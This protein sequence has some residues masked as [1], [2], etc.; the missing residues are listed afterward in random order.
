MS[1]IEKD[2]LNEFFEKNKE[3]I[4]RAFD[5]KIRSLDD[6][7]LKASMEK[8]R[9]GIINHDARFR[10][11]YNGHDNPS[12]K[13]L[14][15]EVVAEFTKYR[16]REG[17]RFDE[18]N[19]EITKKVKRSKPSVSEEKGRVHYAIRNGK[20]QDK[21]FKDDNGNDFYVTNQWSFSGSNPT[22]KR[23][24]DYVDKN[25]GGKFEIIEL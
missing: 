2:L 23:F 20:Y 8:V 1:S 24:K 7:E 25:Y 10:V 4:L 18:I 5:E 15:Y 21:P 9:D 14:M 6:D 22:F 13:L 16:R 3:I 17:I 19:E 12:E 11:I